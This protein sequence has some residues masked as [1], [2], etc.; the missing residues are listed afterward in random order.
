[1]APTIVPPGATSTDPVLA[2]VTPSSGT[3]NWEVWDLYA[4]VTV[5][6]NLSAGGW[7]LTLD[8]STPRNILVTVPS[9]AAQ[10]GDTLGTGRFEL[11]LSAA[12]VATL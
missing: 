9:G 2:N 7:L 1:M 5:A 10:G 11:R 6:S 3:Y 12:Y 4:S 8:S